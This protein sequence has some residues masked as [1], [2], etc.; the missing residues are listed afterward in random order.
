MNYLQLPSGSGAGAYFDFDYS[1]FLEKFP[2]DPL[3]VQAVIKILEQEGYWT[4][5]EQLFLP[6]KVQF[7][8]GK[9]RL[10][11]FEKEHP[12]WEPLIKALL[13]TY[14]GII[15]KLTSVQEKKIAVVL[16]TTVEQIQQSLQ[17]L[18]AR[19]LLNY[20]PKKEKPQLYFFEDRVRSED[21]T[22]H[23]RRYKERKQAYQVRL[24]AMLSYLLDRD[25]C[26]SQLIGNYFGDATLQPC[27]ICDNCLR[28]QKSRS[29]NRQDIEKRICSLL[30]ARSYSYN[31]LQN[32]L[33]EFPREAVQQVIAFLQSEEILTLEMPSQQLQLRKG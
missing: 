19:G 6:S 16:G 12:Q 3:L 23:E 10:H 9:N 18:A 4:F 25:H 22:L 11:A 29:V 20:Q 24:Q 13:R 7:L 26:R 27:G 32:A 1:D 31:E 2:H 14:E 8:S 17:Q 21:L 28:Q 30:S 5:T 33:P 15:D